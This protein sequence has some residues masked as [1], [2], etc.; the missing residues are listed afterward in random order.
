MM[1]DDDGDDDDA[2]LCE[3]CL[4]VGVCVRSFDHLGVQLAFRLNP[5]VVD[6][7]AS[8]GPLEI[9]F[10]RVSSGFVSRAAQLKSPSQPS[11]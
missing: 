7:Q 3:R 11:V 10:V 5:T 6:V 1:G 8:P 9:I 4:C 2:V